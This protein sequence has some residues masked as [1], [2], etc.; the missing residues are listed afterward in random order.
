MVYTCRQERRMVFVYACNPQLYC[1]LDEEIKQ[2][3]LHKKLCNL[4][5]QP[6]METVFQQYFNSI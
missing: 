1:S 2:S 3:F 4:P 6:V 5:V